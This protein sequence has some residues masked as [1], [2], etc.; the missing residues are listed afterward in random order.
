LRS[1]KISELKPSE[2]SVERIGL[3]RVN[4]PKPIAPISPTP[5][6]KQR[7]IGKSSSAMGT[8][9]IYVNGK[10]RTVRDQAT[11]TMYVRREKRFESTSGVSPLFESP[12]K[13]RH[14]NSQV[15]P[16]KV[17]FDLGISLPVIKQVRG[18]S[19]ISS[20]LDVHGRRYKS[21]L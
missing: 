18:M 17:T 10:G 13:L 21:N 20:V 5:S 3:A 15:R 9:L 4:P 12:G 11:Q 6:I 16:E 7:I 2:S 1:E 8:A 14:E 19:Q